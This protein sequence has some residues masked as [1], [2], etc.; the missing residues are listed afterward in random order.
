MKMRLLLSM[1]FASSLL[2]VV[3]P[4][5]YATSYETTVAADSPTFWW[6]GGSSLTNSGSGGTNTLSGSC[7]S[8]TGNTT[9]GASDAIKCSGTQGMQGSGGPIDVGTNATYETWVYLDST[10]S[11]YWHLNYN[12]SDYLGGG[13]GACFI[14]IT[15][16]SK[17]E[18]DCSL[19]ATSPFHFQATSTTTLSTGVWYYLVAVSHNSGGTA[20]VKI[21][22]NGTNEATTNMS[23]PTANPPSEN[24]FNLGNRKTSSSGGYVDTAVGTIQEF[25]IY[26]SVELTSTQ[27][28]NHY[29]AGVPTPT[30]TPTNTP[31]VTPTPTNTATPTPTFTPTP[32]PTNT[33]T[34]T[35]TF[36]VTPTPTNTPGVTGAGVALG[37]S[38][39]IYW[40]PG[41]AT[42]FHSGIVLPAGVTSTVTLRI[43]QFTQPGMAGYG[44]TLYCGSYA[45]TTRTIYSFAPT[46]PWQDYGTFVVPDGGC[47]IYVVTLAYSPGPVYATGIAE[48]Q[49]T[50][51]ASSS[52]TTSINVT[53]RV[54]VRPFGLDS[55]STSPP[56]QEGDV[57]ATRAVLGFSTVSASDASTIGGR[58]VLATTDSS[59][60]YSYTNAFWHTGDPIY[61]IFQGSGWCAGCA[62]YFQFNPSG[63]YSV[64]DVNSGNAIMN[65]DFVVDTQLY[66]GTQ[67]W[68]NTNCYLCSGTG[69]SVLTALGFVSTGYGISPA[70]ESAV[71]T[72]EAALASAHSVTAEETAIGVARFAGGAWLPV[73]LPAGAV[74]T[75][76]VNPS[77]T[78][79]SDLWFPD[80]GSRIHL[81]PQTTTT[82]TVDPIAEPR[83]LQVL[84]G[85]VA[86]VD[87]IPTTATT[88]LPIPTVFPT[89]ATFPTPVSTNQPTDT[90][91][92]TSCGGLL[93]IFPD[94]LGQLLQCLFT[95]TLSA[96]DIINPP[97]DALKTKVGFADAFE[98]IGFICP[99]GDLTNP[100]LTQPCDMT[101]GIWGVMG[102]GDHW[103]NCIPWTFPVITRGTPSDTVDTGSYNLTTICWNI[104]ATDPIPA[105]IKPFITI[106]IIVMALYMLTG[107]ILSF[108]KGSINSDS[109]GQAE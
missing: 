44:E 2:V 90:S 66:R 56:C 68:N 33:L 15:A 103:E 51:V 42:T 28:S 71:S 104:L 54:C 12:E 101:T 73:L 74:V 53:G 13:T 80:N 1:I 32:T 85:V 86:A 81:D 25:A 72:A 99:R 57:A 76:L 92:Y 109:G 91:H 22:V 102:L 107:I 38:F 97:I 63:G 58:S 88:P 35:P 30:P 29:N 7:T 82:I 24:T 37:Q 47:E 70:L 9:I 17:A 69:L 64:A 77:D 8:V 34:P 31:T 46:P 105:A 39:N 52:G 36:T 65:G 26:T 6:K 55:I 106:G 50:N 79:S 41:N 84:T 3:T 96:N 18:A 4:S 11:A 43:T 94:G 78:E 20:Q 100:D 93:F 45:L 40:V 60:R 5:A 67:R 48:W 62:G 19:A 10:P 89:P 108:I 27:I 49:A 23:L 16:S 83:G 14:A 59:G 95:P 61:W 87:T 21:Y 98:I 75:I